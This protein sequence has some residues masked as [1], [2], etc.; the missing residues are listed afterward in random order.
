VDDL[1]PHVCWS[2]VSLVQK[3]ESLGLPTGLP[4]DRGVTLRQVLPILLGSTLSRD[5]VSAVAF[6][7]CWY[8][9]PEV[10][11][12]WLLADVVQGFLDEC[13]L[14]DPHGV[15]S[16][17][18]TAVALACSAIRAWAVG[19]ASKDDVVAA[20]GAIDSRSSCDNSNVSM[21]V[22]ALLDICFYRDDEEITIDAVVDLVTGVT[23][24]LGQD[25]V[26]ARLATILGVTVPP[27]AAPRAGG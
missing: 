22:N 7:L 14:P 18:S 2:R 25:G 9:E 1:E 3:A 6:S 5:D 24:D 15:P 16:D 27:P 26:L 10:V 11:L 19:R 21:V 8:A 17:L 23:R 12:R 4:T 13:L 20:I